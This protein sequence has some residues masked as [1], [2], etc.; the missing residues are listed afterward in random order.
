MAQVTEVI[1]PL[2]KHHVTILRDCRTPPWEFR[3]QVRRI[4]ALL[5]SAAT[6]DLQVV[7]KPIQTP[8]APMVGVALAGRIAL[9][10]I[11]RAGLGL[12]EPLQ[13]MLPHAAVWH[14]GMY[15]DEETATPVEYYCKLPPDHPADVAFILD[16]MLATGG[17]IA[18]AA[19][20][21]ARWGC[22]DVRV[23]S[24]IA[25][26]PGIDRLCH[27]FPSLKIFVAAIDPELN[28]AKFIVPGL[29]DAGDRIFNTLPE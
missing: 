16:P 5:A 10:P 23:L 13:D 19:E 1:H 17:S 29:G 18:M 25:A 8:L 21:L 20:A 27:E 24:I 15:R 2:L 6:A 22:P 28:D 12:V 11:L 9:V 4:A 7:S 14:L 3:Q 26:Q